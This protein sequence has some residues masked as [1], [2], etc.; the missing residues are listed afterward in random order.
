MTDAA[1][2]TIPLT[3]VSLQPGVKQV[4][5]DTLPSAAPRERALVDEVLNGHSK[6][7]LARKLLLEVGVNQLVYHARVAWWLLVSLCA[8][9][10]EHNFEA[11]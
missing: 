8:R 11:V 2:R 7:T 1:A 4:A 6:V 9:G 3:V 5:G 10:V